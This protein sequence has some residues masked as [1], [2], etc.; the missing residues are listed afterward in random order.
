MTRAE[1]QAAASAFEFEPAS[2]GA[3]A[4]DARRRQKRERRQRGSAGER[5]DQYQ[6]RARP[7]EPAVEG[8]G[9]RADTQD[10][11]KRKRER[12]IGAD[13]AVAHDLK[14]PRPRRAAAEAIGDV[15]EP[16]LVQGAGR[17]DDC[18]GRQP[19]ANKHGQAEQGGERKDQRAD[20]AD[21]DAG[22]RRRP[23]DA[24]NVERRA[25][26]R[27]A[28]PQTGE[29]AQGVG[30]VAS[31]AGEAAGRVRAH[32]ARRSAVGPQKHQDRRSPDRR[33]PQL[34][35]APLA[36]EGARRRHIAAAQRADLVVERRHDEEGVKPAC[37]DDERAERPTYIL[38]FKIGD[39][40]GDRG[41]ERKRDEKGDAAAV[42]GT[43]FAEQRLIFEF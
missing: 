13:A 43:P 28:R 4:V 32:E 17:S 24:V 25:R 39:E 22:D 1:P 12:A 2:R 38:G 34:D 23:G 21:R 7:P 20:E 27:L 9:Q 18:R 10:E 31:G 15:G 14:L 41:H 19:R 40:A 42:A 30:N 26:L 8:R 35:N 33:Q 3:R 6:T 16:I 5:G 36:N 11:R 37:N 29:K